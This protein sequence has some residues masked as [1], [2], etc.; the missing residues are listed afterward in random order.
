ML[1]LRPGHYF[2]LITGG[3]LSYMLATQGVNRR[4]LSTALISCLLMASQD[5]LGAQNRGDLQRIPQFLSSYKLLS[6]LQEQYSQQPAAQKVVLHVQGMKC[7]ACA[8][9][10]RRNV[11][12]LDS[13]D[14]CTV[15]FQKGQVEVW[16]NSSEA[17]QPQVLME[18]VRATDDSYKVDVIARKC[19]NAADQRRPCPEGVGA[20][21]QQ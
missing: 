5:L 2:R 19:Y 18:A 3:F 20:L 11:A 7:E 6:S 12:G 15:D 9:R 14:S 8:A 1:H 13:V 17:V 10:L 16:S 4:T 21:G